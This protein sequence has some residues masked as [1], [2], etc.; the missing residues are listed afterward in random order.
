MKLWGEDALLSWPGA[1]DTVI[2]ER[3]AYM[4]KTIFSAA[5]G[6]LALYSLFLVL[7]YCDLAQRV[8]CLLVWPP[9]Q[10]SKVRRSL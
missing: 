7:S 9:L 8:L 1:M 10:M 2:H 5:S 3:D 6:E 4:A